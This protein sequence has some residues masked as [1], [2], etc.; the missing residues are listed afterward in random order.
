MYKVNV[1]YLFFPIALLLFTSCFKEEPL[2]AE[3]DI[4]GA[5]VHVPSPESV[6]YSASDTAAV[7]TRDFASSVIEFTNVKLNA[8]ITALAPVFKVSEGATISPASGTVLDFSKGGQ[9]YTVTSEDGKWSRQYLVRF[10]KPQS[11]YVYDFENYHLSENGKYYIWSDMPDGETPNWATANPG[12]GIARSSATP[13]EYP[14]IPDPD[15]YEGACVRLSTVSTGAWGAMTNKRLASGNLFL[16][17]FDLSKALTQ[18]L[19]STHFGLPTAKKPLRFSGY[20]KYKP[21]QQMQ[22][23]KGNPIEGTDSAAIYAIVYKNHDAN[24]NAVYLTGEDIMTNPLRVGMA[25]LHDIKHTMEWTAFDIEF[26]YWEDIDPETLRSLG[27]NMA[28]QCA[29]SKDGDLYQGALGSTLWIDKL[30]II[31]EE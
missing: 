10:A 5:F 26:D 13:E 7:I 22:D 3:C 25:K 23:A 11:F 19:Q 12:F 28:I 4:E 30:R 9:T 15:G 8:D 6:F 18:T 20:Y 16:G 14:T 27:Y 17:S 2:N 31:T 29:S 24:G 1:K 21:G